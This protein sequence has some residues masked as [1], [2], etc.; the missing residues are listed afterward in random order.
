MIVG[1]ILQER[2]S[3]DL[4]IIKPPL[5]KV[6]YW[7]Q[8]ELVLTS[9]S[10]PEDSLPDFLVRRGVV[11]PDRVTSLL[12]D[13]P[14]AAVA[15][16]HESGMLE[17]SWRQTLVRE[18]LTSQFVPLFS[19]DEGTAAFTERTPIDPEKRVFLQS[20]AA[21]V[22]EGV[23]SITN[24]LVLRRSLGD[25]KREIAVDRGARFGID[26]VP[27][28][29]PERRI[30]AALTERQTI[31]SFLKHFSSDSVT[32]A[33]VVIGLMALG[34]FTT[35]A[36]DQAPAIPHVNADDMQRDLEL[37]AA[38]GSSD[39][40]SLRAVAMSRQIATFDHYQVLDIPRAATRSQI[41]AAAEEAK[42]KYEPSSYPPIVR[43]SL[44]TI[45]RRIDE[46]AGVLKD[47][48]RRQA[49]DKMLQQR[50]GR[51]SAND[52]QKR[53]TQRAIAE[54]NFTKAREL[55]IMGDYYG[56]IVLLKQAVD[57]EPDHVQ[58]WY[59]LGQCQERNPKWRREAAE[60]YQ[61]VLSL[62]P[63]HVD[64]MI[65]L[66]DLYKIEGL[67]SRAQS[68]YEDALKVQPDN[69][70]AMSRLEQYRKR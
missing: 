54:Q 67:A 31:E 6:L 12:S 22:L 30:A 49:Y 52:L 26:D 9:S 23:R 66:G 4:T 59:L 64:A 7:S 60:S 34:T 32:A 35:V 65:S 15:K 44:Q 63:N 55:T 46:A 13:D 18:W 11:P 36:F 50:S 47:A 41:I 5:R 68:C 70:Q 38:I 27:L 29:E 8:G 48:V 42:K 16:F 10:A 58:A 56:A 57:Y 33:K 39:Q 17:L 43:D 51:G 14:T 21:L 37:L 24:G 53:V 45:S 20:T 2:R 40:R 28:T 62:D 1:D 25:L 69:Q 61:R 3:G 19:L